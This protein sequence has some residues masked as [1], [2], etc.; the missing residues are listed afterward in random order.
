MNKWLEEKQ[1]DYDNKKNNIIQEHENLLDKFKNELI[2]INENNVNSNDLEN[3][4]N[5]EI[6]KIKKLQET[7]LED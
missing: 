1:N 6:K 4:Y 2:C 3:D 5:N 7:E